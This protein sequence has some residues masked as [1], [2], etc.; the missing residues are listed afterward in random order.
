M[1]DWCQNTVVFSGDEQKIKE[2]DQLF[3]A[4]ACLERLTPQGQLPPFTEAL[5][6]CLFEIHVKDDILNYQTKW[7][8]N[9]EILVETADHFRT[10]FRHTYYES[11]MK[12]FGKAVYDQG[13]LTDIRLDVED[14]PKFSH[15]MQEQAFMYEGLYYTAMSRSW[16]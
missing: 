4:M 12:I 1:T 6:G 5:E 14:F 7:E 11:G 8:P 10:G 15:D 3:E 2:I 13:M 16:K 9:T